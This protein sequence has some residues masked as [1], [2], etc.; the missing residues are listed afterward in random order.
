MTAS[1]GAAMRFTLP[2]FMV[3]SALVS[4]P[5]IPASD[6]L[7]AR[8]RDTTGRFVAAVRACGVEPAFVPDAE[9]GPNPGVIVYYPRTRTVRISEWDSLPPPIQ[10]FLGAWAEHEGSGLS[11]QA[12]FERLFNDFLVG[13]ELGH[14][15]EHQAGRMA[16]NDFYQGELDANRLAIA[17]AVADKGEDAAR[18]YVEDFGFLATLP[19]PVPPGEDARAWFNANYDRISTSD[20]LAYNWFQGRLMRDAWAMRSAADFCALVRGAA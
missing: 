4:I 13:H 20:P 10:G 2:M 7:E 15:L 1:S 18:D 16:S 11:G 5:A 6:G 8:L 3:F 14:W 19:D 12:L 17:F 9:V